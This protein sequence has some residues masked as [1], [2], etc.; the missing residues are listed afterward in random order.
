[1]TTLD[2]MLAAVAA[3]PT[4]VGTRLACADALQDV[5][6]NR[7]AALY[8][9]LAEPDND[10]HRLNF[11]DCCEEEGDTAR[12]E[13]IRVQ[14]E[15]ANLEGNLDRGY[16][17]RGVSGQGVN[18]I[19]SLKR[20]E[21]RLWDDKNLIV[22][23]WPD[24]VVYGPDFRCDFPVRGFL[25]SFTTTAEIWLAHGDE[26]REQMPVK[27]VALTTEPPSFG[28]SIIREVPRTIAG[29][30]AGKVATVH[31]WQLTE[32]RE[33]GTP[34]PLSGNTVTKLLLEAR[35]PG[36][37]FTLPPPAARSTTQLLD[38]VEAVIQA[39]NLGLPISRQFFNTMFDI[40]PLD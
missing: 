1:M 37:T 27:A 31:E 33:P 20:R 2:T 40:P 17:G 4:D 16:G 30:V 12:G 24:G 36:I 35:W 3:N 21:R 7:K 39:Q 29:I 8:R 23:M 15:L 6:Q 38:A 34:Q 9:V 32:L 10:T 13:F 5:G 28:A 18:A 26:V 22:S 14:C 11:A 19:K 25:E